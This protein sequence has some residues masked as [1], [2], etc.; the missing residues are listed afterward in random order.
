MRR[1]ER[2]NSSRAG[3]VSSRA[4][5]LP[6]CLV[7]LC[8]ACGS[9]AQVGVTAAG[10]PQ[11]LAPV[12]YSAGVRVASHAGTPVSASCRAG[13]QVVGGGFA[14]SDMFEYAAWISASYPSSA[15]TWTV[16]GSAPASFFDL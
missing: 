16:V 13:E 8:L 10:T 14:A 1:I 2:S 12:S 15:T 3:R 9:G 7:A 6:L 4:A 5:M 11:H